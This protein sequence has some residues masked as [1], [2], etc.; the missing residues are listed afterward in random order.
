M[1]KFFKWLLILTAALMVG[2]VVLIYNPSLIKGPLERYLGDLTGYSISLQGDLRIDTGRVT[3][4]TVSNIHLSAPV[5]AGHDDLAFVGH[6]KL[7]LNTGS[8]FKNTVVV[9]S[10]QVD[11]LQV[12]LETGGDGRNNWI[13]SAKPVSEP[14][15]KNSDPVVVFDN[16]Q[17]TNGLLRYL[18]NEK[19]LEHVLS[20]TV[21]DQ[22][23]QLD[24]MLN[25]NLAGGFNSRPLEFKS[26]FGPYINLL[27]GR[28]ISFTGTG[29]LGDLHIN[30]QGFIDDLLHPRLPQVDLEVQGPN[31][32]EITNMFGVDDL[33]SGSFSLRARG[34]MIN[35]SYAASIDGRIGD[36]TVGVSAHASDLVDLDDLDLNLSIKGPNLGAFTRAFGVE[37]WPDSPFSLE[38]DI[39]R[40]GNTLNISG[41]TLAIG[42]AEFLLD[43]LLTNFPGLDSSRVRLSVAGDD[44]AQFRQ[45]LGLPG[46]EPGHLSYGGNSMFHHRI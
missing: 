23:Q 41:L 39:N 9:E 17:V 5:W 22:V 43:A 4:L 6:I 18:N 36:V 28:D 2:V 29:D 44:V 24:G 26:T 30:T 20:I 35:T 21:L 16:I 34:E 38:G 32:D 31:I 7:G 14:N 3:E 11:N 42:G 1:K 27:Q 46:V 12:N 19:G 15:D 33:G 25:V 45:L 40:L 13:G 37:N 10:L 8:I